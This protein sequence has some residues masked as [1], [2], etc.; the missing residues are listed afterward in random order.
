MAICA[1]IKIIKI[2]TQKIT[3]KKTTVYLLEI[4]ISYKNLIFRTTKTYLCSI[5][6][7][8][9]GIAKLLNHTPM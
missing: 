1:Q 2:N 3:A 6:D 5:Y 9:L 4:E 8:L 7:K